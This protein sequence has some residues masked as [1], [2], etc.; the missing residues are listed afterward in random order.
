[1]LRSIRLLFATIFFLLVSNVYAQ[2][3]GSELLQGKETTTAVILAQ[4]RS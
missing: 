3:S 2:P 4:G 1:M